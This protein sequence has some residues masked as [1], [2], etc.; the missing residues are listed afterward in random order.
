MGKIQYFVEGECEEKFIDIYKSYPKNIL[1]SGKI[2]IIN[3]VSEKITNRTLAVLDKDTTI[4]L[5]YDTDIDNNIDILK[6]NIG[7]LKKWGFKIFHLQSIKNFEDELVYSSSMK[8]IKELF[9]T[10]SK[11]EHKKKF[12]KC[13]NLFEKLEEKNF[14]INKMWSRKN[15]EK[16]FSIYSIKNANQN[17]FNKK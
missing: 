17:I 10:K 5:I 11:E 2:K 7:I 1:K 13:N 8:N 9:N 6:E 3:F 4:I 14:D 15:D 16:P 12:M